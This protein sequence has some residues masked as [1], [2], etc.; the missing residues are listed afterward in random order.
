MS[1]MNGSTPRRSRR[2]LIGC[3]I[4]LALVLSAIVFAPVSA[5]AES[6]PAT[7]TYLALGDSISFGYSAERFANHKAAESP[8]FFEE[9]VANDFAKDLKKSSEVGKSIRLVNDACPGETSNGLIGENP[10]VGGKESTESYEEIEG[11]PKEQFPAGGYQGLGDYHP[12][13]YT[14]HTHL[15]LHNGGYVQG[16]KEIS[17]LEE[18]VSTVKGTV[19]PVKAITLNIGSNDQLAAI[20][21]CED[22]V[23]VEF[24][25]TGKSKYGASPSVAVISCITEA[26]K[27]VLV[28]HIINN[29]ATIITV[30]RE[31]GY[32]GPIVLLGFYNP[33]TFILPGSDAL[34][35]GTNEAVE[36]NI[37][38][39]FPDVTYAN[40][41]PVFNAGSSSI[42]GGKKASATKEKEAIC[43][44]TEMCNP[45]DPG[46]A[47]GKGDIHP[48][49]KGYKALAKLVNAAYLENAG[50]EEV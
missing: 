46:G 6:E 35:A 29:L 21:Q 45:N 33:D 15:P 22:E 39:N 31:A 1:A 50:K 11:M 40:P 42:P 20:K 23:T 38:K 28:P 7:T 9:G 4:A 18:A 2:G 27:N 25:N 19:S 32:K 44:Y 8:S 26:S 37:V 5:Q 47:E 3:C 49:I 16:G 41:F 34:Q 12:C 10:E 36:A 13:A 48:T 43:K 17:Q 24:T 14:F 30:I